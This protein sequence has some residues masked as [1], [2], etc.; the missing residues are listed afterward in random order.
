MKKL[1]FTLPVFCSLFI[2]DGN[3]QFNHDNLKIK[4]TAEYAGNTESK[5]EQ[6]DQ[7][8][9]FK[10][11]RLYPIVANATFIKANSDLGKFTLLKQAIEQNKIVI[12]ETGATNL[13]NDQNNPPDNNQINQNNQLNQSQNNQ[14]NQINQSLNI[15]QQYGNGDVSGTVN[16][17]F[18]KN[19]STDTIFL[20]AGEVV[21]GGKQDRVIAQDLVL[22]P[23]EEVNLSAFCVEHNRWTT[24]D[25]NG[26][27]FNGYFNVSSMDIRKIVTEDKDQS[28][29]WNKV[30][31]HTSKNG[32]S[33]D[34]KTYTNLENSAEYQTQV[35]AYMEKFK[36]IFSG[37]STV[38]GVIAV[39]GD[40][41]IG[42]D[43]FA[44]NQLFKDSYE[45]M[46]YSY[47]SYAITNGSEVK[48]TNEQVYAYLD[49]ILKSEEGQSEAVEKNGTMYEYNKKKIHMSKY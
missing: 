9:V 44:T 1:I 11:L 46:V 8:F 33:S 38:I 45:N 43:M 48:I 22:A 18:A 13:A 15:N 21:K 49:E 16:T 14:S 42:L 36:T 29:V 17:L 12:T 7:S 23:G 3:A 34:T 6:F 4:R 25:G 20:M 47:I 27:Q 10:N 40:Q 2:F 26:G 32:A 5:P 35:N 24:T 30:D 37:D 39:T 19:V 28:G 31:E 41:V